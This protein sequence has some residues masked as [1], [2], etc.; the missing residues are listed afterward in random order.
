MWTI[1]IFVGGVLSVAGLMASLGVSTWLASILGPIL[2]PIMSSPWIFIPC[3]CIITYL[4]RFVI[5]SQS[6]CMAVMIAIFGSL[7]EAHGINIF[8]L[9]FTSW[10]SGTCWNV[11]YQNP[12][13]AGLIKMC[14]PSLDFATASKGSYAYCI[15]N[16]IAMTCSVPLWM[17]LGLL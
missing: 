5:V 1:T 9:V 6:C 10:V 17:A 8:V 14:D 3:L 4:L 16:L 11:A 2:A 7:L 12:A 15:I 13:S